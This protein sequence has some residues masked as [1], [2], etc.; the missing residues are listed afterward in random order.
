MNTSRV[1]SIR[2]AIAYNMIMKLVDV[3]E[4]FQQEIDADPGYWGKMSDH[5]FR[6]DFLDAMKTEIAAIR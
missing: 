4:D 3:S 1:Q 2:K 6:E 5:Q